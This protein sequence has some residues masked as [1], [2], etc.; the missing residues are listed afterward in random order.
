MTLP[1]APVL[2]FSPD[3]KYL[4]PATLADGR[5]KPFV[6]VTL[7][8]NVASPLPKICKAGKFV[9]VLKSAIT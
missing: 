5:K 1:V 3:V 2:V 6:D 9:P 8:P 7:A 4:T